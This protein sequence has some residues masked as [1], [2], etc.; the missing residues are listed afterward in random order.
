M[1]FNSTT[2]VEPLLRMLG[3]MNMWLKCYLMRLVALHHV[4]SHDYVGFCFETFNKPSFITNT[5]LGWPLLYYPTQLLKFAHFILLHLHNYWC[6]VSKSEGDLLALT[7]ITTSEMVKVRWLSLSS[8]THS[9]SPG[10][11]NTPGSSSRLHGQ[12]REPSRCNLSDGNE[13]VPSNEECDTS[14]EK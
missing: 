6:L 11:R 14:I 1:K 12:S 9:S 5:S 7:E 13:D 3:Y 10:P 4:S 8:G 2:V